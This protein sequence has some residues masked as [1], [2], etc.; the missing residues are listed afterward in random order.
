M[1]YNGTWLWFFSLINLLKRWSEF[2]LPQHIKGAKK[3]LLGP[4]TN[5]Q[6]TPSPVRH[7]VTSDPLCHRVC[8]TSSRD[9]ESGRARSQALVVAPLS[10]LHGH[11]LYIPSELMHP[12]LL[13]PVSFSRSHCALTPPSLSPLSWSLSPRHSAVIISFCRCCSWRANSHLVLLHIIFIKSSNY[14]FGNVVKHFLQ[15]SYFIMVA[16]TLWPLYSEPV[17][18]QNGEQTLCSLYDVWFPCWCMLF[19]GFH[20]C[21]QCPGLCTEVCYTPFLSMNHC[22]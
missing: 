4:S 3:S 12:L 10:C 20:S 2:C 21:L 8:L 9:A 18:L 16:V 17:I 1:W 5:D 7:S 6:G 14:F 15:F 22:I 11:S 13:P 19:L